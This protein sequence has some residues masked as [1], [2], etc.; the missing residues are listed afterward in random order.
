MSRDHTL[1]QTTSSKGSTPSYSKPV[2]PYKAIMLPPSKAK[3]AA[4][5]VCAIMSELNS[6]ELEG[7]KNAFIESLDEEVVEEEQKDF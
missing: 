6:K 1:S 4:Q 7:A 5:K 2:T 3:E